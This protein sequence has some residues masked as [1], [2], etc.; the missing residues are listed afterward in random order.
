MK[1]TAHILAQS[2]Q[3]F[4]LT[5]LA[6][7]AAL[8][9]CGCSSMK[10]EVANDSPALSGKARVGN[11]YFL[12]RGMV[13]ITGNTEQNGTYKL[14]ISKF[15]VPDRNHRYFLKQNMNPFFD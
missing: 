9:T 3:P 10:T 6:C 14:T 5:T 4:T 7:L 2:I 1:L 12:P 8:G 15:N 13:R 11:F